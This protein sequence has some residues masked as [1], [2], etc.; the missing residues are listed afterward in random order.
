M[1][2]DDGSTDGTVSVV[3]KYMEQHT[4]ELRLVRLH[5]NGGK[6]AALKMGVREC[7]GD[8]IL[9]VSVFLPVACHTSSFIF[10]A[11]CI[12]LYKYSFCCISV[13]DW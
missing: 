5:T 11:L 12:I 1:L 7:F 13:C 8:V 10:Y 4:N 9:I 6:G 3:Q 2:V